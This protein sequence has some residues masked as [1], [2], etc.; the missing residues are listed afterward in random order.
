MY[1]PGS[2]N[3]RDSNKICY[4][5][6]NWSE[7]FNASLQFF[8]KYPKVSGVGTLGLRSFDLRPTGRQWTTTNRK[9]LTSTIRVFL[10]FILGT[11]NLI[12]KDASPASLCWDVPERKLWN[13]T[14]LFPLFRWLS[15]REGHL[16]LQREVLGPTP[17]LK[18][19]A[20]STEVE[21][22]YHKAPQLVTIPSII[23]SRFHSDSPFR[24]L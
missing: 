14:I 3:F 10:H 18:S 17:S 16:H 13:C 1:Y 8:H 21:N 15:Q 12:P 11:E 22:I 19:T 2:S 20:V 7:V 6:K 4:L 5:W 24:L 23:F 9:N